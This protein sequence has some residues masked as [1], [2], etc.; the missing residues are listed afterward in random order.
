MTTSASVVPV[1]AHRLIAVTLINRFPIFDIPAV[2]AA[3]KMPLRRYSGT[4]VL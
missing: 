1:V 4:I 3:A 2:K